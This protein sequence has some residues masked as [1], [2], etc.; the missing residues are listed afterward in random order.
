MQGRNRLNRPMGRP[1]DWIFL[2]RETSMENGPAIP[3]PGQDPGNV[4]TD[5]VYASFAV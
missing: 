3:I 4:Q 2:A 1:R 5:V